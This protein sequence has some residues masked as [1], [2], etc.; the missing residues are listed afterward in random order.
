MHLNIV[1]HKECITGS[2]EFVVSCG[3]VHNAFRFGPISFA[4]VSIDMRPVWLYATLDKVLNP[5][6]RSLPRFP[7]T[8]SFSPAE[9]LAYCLKRLLHIR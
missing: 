1:V 4:A 6:M 3:V 5:C 7:D 8:Q 9:S 2:A